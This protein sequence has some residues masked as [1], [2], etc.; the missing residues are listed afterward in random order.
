MSHEI[1]VAQGVVN[2][3]EV[4]IFR[5]R[6]DGKISVQAFKDGRWHNMGGP[7][8]GLYTVFTYIETLPKGPTKPIK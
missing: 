4:R 7:F 1:P 6:V 2:G 5:S 3:Y 8:P